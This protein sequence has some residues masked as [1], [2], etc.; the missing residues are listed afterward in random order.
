MTQPRIVTVTM[1][2]SPRPVWSLRRHQ[3]W[4]WTATAANGRVLAVSSESYTNR[5]DCRVAISLLFGYSTAVIL[6]DGEMP[7]HYLRA[8]VGS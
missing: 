6:R 2:R 7:E 1:H 8:G 5:A 4:R 3:P